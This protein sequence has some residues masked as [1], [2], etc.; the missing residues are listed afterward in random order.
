MLGQGVG[1]AEIGKILIFFFLPSFQQALPINMF[2]TE[3]IN[4][5]VMSLH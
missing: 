2:T 5:F 4:S 1:K 3:L